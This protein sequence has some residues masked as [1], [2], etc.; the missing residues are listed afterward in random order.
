MNNGAVSPNAFAKIMLVKLIPIAIRK[1]SE[2]QHTFAIPSAPKPCIATVAFSIYVIYVIVFLMLPVNIVVVVVVLLQAVLAWQTWS[3]IAPPED[4]FPV[5]CLC[6]IAKSTIDFLYTLSANICN[7]A[8]A[9]AFTKC[10]C[11]AVLLT[12]FMQVTHYMT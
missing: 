3:A 4:H 9:S 2:K 6:G 7:L 1:C 10:L 5:L 8:S 12:T 11:P